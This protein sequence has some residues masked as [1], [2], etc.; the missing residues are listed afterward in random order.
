VC[1]PSSYR[2]LTE[3]QELL[4]GLKEGTSDEK[5][6]TVKEMWRAGDLEP[7]LE[8]LNRM[9]SRIRN[10]WQVKNSH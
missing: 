6:P 10:R 1:S 3:L 7:K 2:K 5:L 9:V 8:K 4:L